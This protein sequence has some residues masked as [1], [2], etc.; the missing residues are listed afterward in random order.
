MVFIKLPLSFKGEGEFPQKGLRL[1][2]FL[3]VDKPPINMVRYLIVGS[4]R[5]VEARYEGY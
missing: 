1:P 4:E 5:L 2:Q 3:L